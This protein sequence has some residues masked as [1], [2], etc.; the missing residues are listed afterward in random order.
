MVEIGVEHAMLTKGRKPGPSSG[1]KSQCIAQALASAIVAGNLSDGAF[2][3]PEN[4]LAARFEVSRP[5]VREA[6]HKVAGAGLV[7]SRHGIGTYVKPESSWGLFDSLVMEAYVATG[8]LPRVLN[9]IIE[10]R[11]MVEV[12]AAGNAAAR[13]GQVGLARLGDW[14]EQMDDVIADPDRTARADIAFHDAIV[15]VTENRFLVAI[16]RQPRRLLL[17]A[18]HLTSTAGGLS[19]RRRALDE[20]RRVYD[21]IREGNGEEAREAMS[22]HVSNSE[23]D[24]RRAILREGGDHASG[25]GDDR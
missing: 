21:A 13:I 8:N 3:P 9:E 5:I 18:R 12:E 24:L 20:H 6:L 2:L 16:A 1:S 19:G 17:E 25:R 15:A 14:L 23:A 10:L 7:E 4:E 22:V 11:R